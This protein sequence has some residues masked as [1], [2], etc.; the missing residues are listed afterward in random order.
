MFMIRFALGAFALLGLAGCGSDSKNSAGD[1]DGGGAPP[2]LDFER[3]DAAISAFLTDHGITGASGVV[4]HRDYGLVHLA[5]Y[6]EYPADRLYLVASSSKVV[7]AGILMRLADQGKLD[8]DGPIGKYVSAWGMN[9]KS[10]LEV[11][12]LLSN[13]SGLVGLIDDP[14]YGPYICQYV[15][16]GSLSDCAKSVF[17]A[18]DADRRK[19]PDTSFHYGGGQWQLAGGIAELVSGKP[20]SDLVKE[21]YVDPCDAPS[22]GYTNQYTKAAQQGAGGVSAALSYPA[23]FQ[24]DVENL[25]VTNNPSIEGGLYTTAEDYG[26]ILLMHLRGGTCGGNRVLSK[27]AVQRMR[28]DRILEKYN[29][30]TAAAAGAATMMDPS[31]SSP[32][33]GYGMGWWID[34]HHEGVFADPGAYG[35]FPWLDLPRGYAAFIVIEQSA[36]TGAQ[37][38]NQVKPALDEVFD[39]AK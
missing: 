32:L 5:G 38:W 23:F 33:E 22:L 19:A 11:A 28:V 21:T 16:S 10:D 14:T 9:D 30:S 27:E 31:G 7:S 15:D 34:R 35:A 39:S 25:P 26:K 2:A 24:A 6:G 4:V 3:Y 36:G 12:Q 29:G 17:T 37:L 8:I 18:D 1:G 20:W 13:S